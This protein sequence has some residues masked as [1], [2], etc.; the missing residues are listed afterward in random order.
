[1]TKIFMGWFLLRDL[2]GLICV[3]TGVALS[4]VA[5]GMS[6]IAAD[7]VELGKAVCHGEIKSVP[8]DK[9]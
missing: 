5:F 8:H 2:A 9:I 1:M 4:W 3:L 6:K 7:F